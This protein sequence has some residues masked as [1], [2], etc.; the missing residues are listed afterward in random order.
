MSKEQ[1]DKAK[2]VI[3]N[4]L[5]FVEN[6]SVLDESDRVLVNELIEQAELTNALEE[7]RKLDAEQNVSLWEQNKRYREFVKILSDPDLIA[8][9]TFHSNVKSRYI[10][11]NL[12]I[13]WITKKAR[14]I[15]IEGDPH[16]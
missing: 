7:T 8:Q 9:E 11:A 4:M 16:D 13:H 1:L 2:D 15:V 6:V 12:M 14:K 5:N 10:D 3:E